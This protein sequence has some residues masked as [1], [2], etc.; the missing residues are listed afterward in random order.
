MSNQ[1]IKAIDAIQEAQKIAM[2]PFVF[3]ATV[4]LRKLGIFDLIFEKRKKGGITLEAIAEELKLSTYGVGVLLEIAESSDIV[5][6]NETEHFE[7]TTIGYF[8]AYNETVNVNLNFTNEVCYK[9]LFHLDE[10]IKTGKPSGLKELGDWP[11]VYEGLS[12]LTPLQQK[13]WFDFDHHYSDDIFAEALELLFKKDRKKIFD[14]GANTGKFTV[15]CCTYNSDVNI[16]MIDLP[17]QLNKAKANVEKAG[18]QD[19]VKGHEIDWLSDNPTIPSDAETIWMSQFLDCFSKEEILKVLKTCVNSMNE[20]SE[21]IIIETF[22]DRQ[23]FDN[24]K[25]ILEATSLYFTVIA[26]GNSKMYKATEF[27]EIAEEAG[28]QLNEDVEIGEYHTMFT[29]SKA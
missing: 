5:S 27:K 15:K 11:T 17:G 14:I 2:A 18:F 23:K 20:N 1:S 9:G 6:K 21:L 25:F 16:T 10:A 26:N 29:F 28:L 8:L 7:L 13:S 22:T 12:K 4:S 19:R 24:A 3:Q